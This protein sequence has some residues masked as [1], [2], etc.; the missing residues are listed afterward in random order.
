MF[1]QGMEAL[2]EGQEAYIGLPA[3]NGGNGNIMVGDTLSVNR[4]CEHPEGAV[5]FIGY[6]LGEEMQEKLAMDACGHGVSGFPV[7]SSSLESMFRN[8]EELAESED[9]LESPANFMGY[10]YMERPLS[11]ESI[12][13]IRKLLQSA[14]PQTHR[15]DEISDII[16]EETPAYFS[17]GKPAEEVC[18]I[19]QSRIQ[20]YLDEMD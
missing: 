15:T 3:E 10:D 17:G 7:T 19:L 8:V 13:K 11:M 4:A 16:L 20:L 9:V 6:L 2:F 14:E 1:V 5:E 12:Q 18:G